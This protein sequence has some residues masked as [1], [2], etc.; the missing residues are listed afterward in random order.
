TTEEDH[1]VTLTAAALL[2]NDADVDGD[3]LRVLTVGE[4]QNALTRVN[5]DGSV[6]YTPGLDFA[7]NDQ[8]TYTVSD[9]HEGNA[10]GT[11][12]ITVTPADDPPVLTADA[13]EATA[14]VA[15]AAV[16]A[17]VVAGPM[18]AAVAMVAAGATATA[19]VVAE[20]TPAGVPANR[21]TGGTG[22][23]AAGAN[24][25]DPIVAAAPPEER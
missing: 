15:G 19:A 8:F 23:P 14:V 11:V 21:E 12:S 17:M 24:V 5:P 25:E 9:G 3:P 18:A 16:L 13:V 4:A 1:P 7:G 20:A 6:T 22:G 2:G 10:T